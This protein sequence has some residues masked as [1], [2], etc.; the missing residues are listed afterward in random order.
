MRFSGI[1]GAAQ[2][3]ATSSEQLSTVKNWVKTG[4][5]RYE[6][7]AHNKEKSDRQH[8]VAVILSLQI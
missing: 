6:D 7:Q 2:Y 1:S 4:S 8:P 3:F 5:R